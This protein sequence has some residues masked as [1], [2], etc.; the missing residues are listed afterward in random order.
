MT[1]KHTQ[2]I[3]GPHAG[4]DDDDVYVLNL[5]DFAGLDSNF[6]TKIVS[7]VI[8]PCATN[9]RIEAV[10]TGFARAP[11][12]VLCSGRGETCGESDD[13]EIICEPL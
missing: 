10:I 3:G 4:D 9:V 11:R 5:D 6:A 13:G 1:R 7:R 8:A 2:D 12:K